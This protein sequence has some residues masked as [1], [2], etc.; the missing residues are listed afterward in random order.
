MCDISLLQ[1][2]KFNKLGID[3]VNAK[4]FERAFRTMSKPYNGQL[5][6]SKPPKTDP[7][8]TETVDSNSALAEDEI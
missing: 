3:P 2:Q 6:D 1:E 7:V 5:N 8:P 4:D